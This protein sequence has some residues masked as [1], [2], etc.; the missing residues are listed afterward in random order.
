MKTL[1]W[2]NKLTLLNIYFRLSLFRL[3]PRQLLSAR[4]LDFNLISLYHPL[5]NVHPHHSQVRKMW[6]G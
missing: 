2:L 5:E 1:I 3:E 6:R 4:A